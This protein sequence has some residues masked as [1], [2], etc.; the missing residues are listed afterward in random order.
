MSFILPWPDAPVARASKTI[1]SR[2]AIPIPSQQLNCVQSPHKTMATNRALR[3]T[4]IALLA[5]VDPEDLE[6]SD[7]SEPEDASSSE[8]TERERELEFDGYCPTTPDE[9]ALVTE[10]RSRGSDTMNHCFTLPSVGAHVRLPA[11][12]WAVYLD[13]PDLAHRIASYTCVDLM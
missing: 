13:I 4:L 8:G 5:G 10:L 3:R 1:Q 11:L 6:S 2:L 7:E 9:I 12:H